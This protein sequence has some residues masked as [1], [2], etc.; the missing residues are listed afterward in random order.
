MKWRRTTKWITALSV[1]LVSMLGGV[2][3]WH[4]FLHPGHQHCIK[5]AMF[6]LSSY[7][8]RHNGKYPSSPK[9]WGDALLELASSPED[10]EW[11][12]LFV[13]VD[14]DGSR[15]IEALRTGKDVDEAACTRIYV[16]GLSKDSDPAIAILFDR[17]AVKGGDHFRDAPG[18]ARLREVITLGWSMWHI[19][20]PDWPAFVSQQRELLLKEGF[21]EA[22]IDGF[23]ASTLRHHP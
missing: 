17:Y 1:G 23:Y 19:K 22:E 6:V 10:V 21:S 4:W 9:G 13:G 3:W 20:E 7:E 18:Q 11:I 8:E 16:Q 15:L 5:G 2:I 14:D 12:P